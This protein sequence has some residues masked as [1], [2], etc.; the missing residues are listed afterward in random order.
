MLITQL[1]RECLLH[2]FSFLD[3][4]SRLRLSQTCRDLMLVFQDPLLWPLLSFSSLA[5]LTKKNYILGPALKYLSVCWYSSRVKIC[6]I[7]DWDKTSLQKSM[8]SQHQNIVSDFLLKVS[9]RCPNLRSLTLS[10]CA[11]VTDE[12]LIKILSSCPQLRNLK[13]ENCSGMSDRTLAA[14]PTFAGRL[15]I[16]HVNFC[17]NV[18]QSGLCQVQERCPRLV[19]QAIRSADMIADR[20]PEPILQRIPR[21]LILR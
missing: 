18:T 19:M 16:L 13:L 21:K 14:I 17:R 3:K 6:N 4:D 2:L 8:C 15:H 1:N 10:G 11:H 12:V 7:E 9:D 20:T 5:E